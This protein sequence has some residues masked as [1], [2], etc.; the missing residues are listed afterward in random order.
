MNV[1]HSR[2][3]VSA[4]CVAND[5]A[6]TMVQ[7]GEDQTKELGAPLEVVIGGMCVSHSG[8]WTEV[9]HS[10]DDLRKVR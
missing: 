1:C 3:G 6:K 4:R 8:E 2:D 9:I 5:K 10:V 7:L